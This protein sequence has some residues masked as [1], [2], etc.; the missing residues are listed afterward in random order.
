[1]GYKFYY[2][3]FVEDIITG[4]V[5]KVTAVCDYFGRRNRQ[6]LVESIDDTGR[7][8]EQWTEEDRLKV[9]KED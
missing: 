6:Y 4:Y 5:G 3:E 1:M 2:N 8:I 9:A 7:P